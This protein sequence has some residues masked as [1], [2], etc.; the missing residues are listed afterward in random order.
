MDK[1][2]KDDEKIEEEKEDSQETEEKIEE[3][4]EEL[5]KSEK[6]LDNDKKQEKSHNKILKGFLIGIISFAVMFVIVIFIVKSVNN[7]S[8]KGIEFEVDKTTLAGKTIYRTS[9]PVER[10]DS[11]TGKVISNADYNFWLRNDPRQLDKNVPITNGDL[12]FTKNIVLDLTTEELFCEG[13][14]NLG[15]MNAVNLFNILGFN[16]LVKNE[17]SKYEPA[18]EFTFITIQIGNSTNIEKKYAT[19]DLGKNGEVETKDENSYNLNINN[20]EVLPAFER[21]MVEAFVRYEEV[22]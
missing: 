22:K 10:K 6:E 9:I 11:I 17:T 20:C 7:F 8:Y 1:E 12:T 14:W 13:D 18:E 19:M 2:K 15:L 3:V 16:I 5:E 21:L 4:K